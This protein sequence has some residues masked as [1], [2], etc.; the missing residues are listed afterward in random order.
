MHPDVGGLQD[1]GERFLAQ[2]ERRAGSVERDH[3]LIGIGSF[4]RCQLAIEQVCRHEMMRAI[5]QPLRQ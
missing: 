3:W 2:S 5:S 4:E 1:P